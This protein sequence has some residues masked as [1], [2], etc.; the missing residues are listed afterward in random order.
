MSLKRKQ[1]RKDI[2]RTS[3]EKIERVTSPNIQP[4]KI[5]TPELFKK[6][7][8][9][10]HKAKDHES[11]NKKYSFMEGM[12]DKL[13]D[14]FILTDEKPIH[15][16]KNSKVFKGIYQEKKVVLK[17]YPHDFPSEAAIR[18]YQKDYQISSVL[19]DKNPQFF[20]EPLLFHHEQNSM[21]VIKALHGVS[22]KS[23]LEKNKC[24]KVEEFLN[25]AIKVCEV[26]QLVHELNIVHCDIK[27]ENIL[28]DKEK[29]RYTIVDFEASALVSLKHP[30]V[31]KSEAI[32]ESSK[33]YDELL[34]HTKT[35]FETLKVNI[36]YANLLTIMADFKNAVNLTFQIFDLY[37]ISK[38]MPRKDMKLFDI[39]IQNLFDEVNDF[40]KNIESEQELLDAI[41]KQADEEIILLTR[42]YTEVNM[43]LH[44][45]A[46]LPHLST[47]SLLLG[48]KLAIKHG[49][50]PILPSLLAAAS[51]FSQ[52]Y[53]L[54][55]KPQIMGHIAHKM[56]KNITNPIQAFYT[57][58]YTGLS[59]P[60]NFN[61]TELMKL[62]EYSAMFGHSIGEKSWGSYAYFCNSNATVLNGTS[63]ENFH[64]KMTEAANLVYNA[65]HV[66]IGDCISCNLQTIKVITG[67]EH[68]YTPDLKIPG[69]ETI[70]WGRFS[71]TFHKAVS[72]Y[73]L[74]KFTEAKEAIDLLNEEFPRE[75]MALPHYLD[76]PFYRILIH[77]ENYSPENDSF[78]AM[79]KSFEILEKFNM[80]NT[81]YFGCR[82]YLAKALIATINKERNSDIFELFEQSILTSAK[83]PWV[84]AL[85]YE[86][87]ARFCE[88]KIIHKS[89]AKVLW[90]EAFEKFKNMNAVCKYRH[91]V[92][93]RDSEI[94][95]VSTSSNSSNQVISFGTANFSTT[96]SGAPNIDIQTIIKSATAI[97]EDLDK[98]KLLKK[99]NKV[100]VENAGAEKG[101][102]ILNEN[103]KFFVHSEV[104]NKK[105]LQQNEEIT[106]ECQF[107]SK[108]LYAINS[109]KDSLLLDIEQFNLGVEFFSE[110]KFDEA[111]AVFKSM[112]VKGIVEYYVS[113]CKFYQPMILPSEWKGEIKISKDGDP[114]SF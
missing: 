68:E 90:S 9:V 23:L 74:K 41:P 78:E 79:K 62:L 31:P 12:T 44:F 10:T 99:L 64:Q 70:P 101:F 85:A 71:Y 63:Y 54:D 18:F 24:L 112:D 1:S 30:N 89:Y 61:A 15:V 84:E 111:L 40:F 114:I 57:K 105:S 17:I 49:N 51:W 106:L 92:L 86:Y 16:S 19:Y 72:A 98:E 21:I 97:T 50:H 6:H 83:S 60:F 47:A 110:K 52:A 88:K 29:N 53:F 87:F 103:G 36:E 34:K 13:P 43:P 67:K 102:I 56:M 11:Q 26:L 7:K 96:T 66:F 69:F 81:K 35:D 109:K 42:Y 80:M 108:K 104:S 37:D 59:A 48:V 113:V 22:L 8:T 65:K 94:S 27:P 82:Y 77:F 28:F 25:L 5:S 39:W 100:I 55:P 3:I 14:D 95:N 107:H 32:R 4:I 33:I 38:D 2:L 73:L 91:I 58:F 76:S 75:N 46:C 45:Q 20:P 93:R